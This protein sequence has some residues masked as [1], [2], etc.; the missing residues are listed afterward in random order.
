MSRPGSKS[1]PREVACEAILK[2]AMA[3]FAQEGLAGARMDEIA[4]A[5]K[6][7]KALL[8]YY[9]KD[10]ENLYGAVLDRVFSGLSAQVQA[11]LDPKLGPKARILAYAAAHFD[12][13]AAA[14]S[15]YPRV[16]M[17]E[18]MRAGRSGSPHLRRIARLYLRPVQ[19]K[20]MQTFQEGIAR[21]EVRRVNPHHA[22]ISIV[23]MNV[24]YF[25][26]APMLAQVT[27]HNPLTTQRIA[28]RRE[29]LLDFI[30]HALFVDGPAVS[31]RAKRG[32]R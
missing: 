6:V 27:G 25:S 30:S 9:F 12:Y 3:E 32:Q 15:L 10:K 14:S 19:A 1:R 18:M 23:A 4:R 11:A 16:V 28:E 13:I 29:A 8:H 24:F 7:N 2:A 31:S 26:S 17:R 21:G 22:L 5:A 20:L